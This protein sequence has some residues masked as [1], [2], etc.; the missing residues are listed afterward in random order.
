MRQAYSV[1]WQ[2]EIDLYRQF[3]TTIILEGNIIDEQLYYVNDSARFA[4]TENYLRE[5]LEGLGYEY[6]V[7]FDHHNGFRFFENYNGEGNKLRADGDK[8]K[9][10]KELFSDFPTK[11]SSTSWFTAQTMQYILQIMQNEKA[12][13][14]FIM[15][16]ASHYVERPDSLG[17]DHFAY[18]MLRMATQTFHPVACP[19]DLDRSLP[20]CIFMLTEKVNDIPAW[21]YLNNPLVRTVSISLPDR[22]VRRSFIESEL[23][24]YLPANYSELSAEAQEQA[25]Q[26]YIN[27]FIAQTDGFRINEMKAL[28]RVMDSKQLDLSRVSTAATLFKHGTDKNP[29]EHGDLVGK[30]SKIEEILAR[31]V[32]GQDSAIKLAANVIR[33]AV[34]GLAGL[35]HSRKGCRPKGILFFAGP[36]GVGKTELAKAISELV[37]GT[38]EHVVRFDMSEYREAHSDARLL[39]APPGYVGYE[40]GGQLTQAVRREPFSVLLFDEIEKAH[41]SILDKFLQILEDGRL[42]DSK[43]ETVYFSDSLI[44]FTSNLG[45]IDREIDPLTGKEE[46]RQV[47]KYGD[48]GCNEPEP[49]KAEEMYNKYQNGILERI[50][51]FFVGIARPEIKNRIGDNFVVFNFISKKAIHDIAEKIMENICTN[52]SSE[53][54]ISLDVKTSFY[55]NLYKA[56][57]EQD[58]LKDG[59]RGVGNM[60]E[61]CFIKP[62]A[63]YICDPEN[64]V[65][66]GDTITIVGFEKQQ[67]VVQLICK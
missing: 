30:L 38:E 63:A 12:P 8:M 56:L 61:S 33:S 60:I 36:T 65:K 54:K 67:G 19:K 39:G 55:E 9:A 21:F 15:Q 7:F 11:S 45:I 40:Q 49:E 14:A 46:N 50:E 24:D 29:W 48:D 31:R 41:P 13:I 51:K 64:D 10:F 52:I 57:E 47:V 1:K 5:Y 35:Q 34:H 44:I 58:K 62:L 26:K 18:S 59:G 66:A 20:N 22:D 6:V 43:G 2:Q 32:K 4:S 53:K 3:N 23:D 42:T 37:F 17:G 25:K 27:D 16:E 28:L